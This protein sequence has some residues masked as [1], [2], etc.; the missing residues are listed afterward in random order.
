MSHVD[1]GALHAY[2]DGELGTEE[3][4][5]V[6]AHVAECPAC[7]QRLEEERALIA[8]ASE[9]LALAEPPA[10][11]VPPFR[12]GDPRPPARLW[13][14]VRLPL[15]W[16]ATV[17]LA[18]GIGMYLTSGR[19]A[20][21]LAPAADSTAVA[22]RA[23]QAQQRPSARKLAARPAAK[24]P[25]APQG[26]MEMEK[27]EALSRAQPPAPVPTPANA[28]PVAP[29]SLDSARLVLG[30]TPVALPGA[31]IIAVRR[32]R[33]IGYAAVVIVEQRLDSNTVVTLIE[34]RPS[35]LH[36]D[37]VVVTAAPEARRDADSFAAKREGE[38]PLPARAAASAP[39][40]KLEAPPGFVAGRLGAERTIGG[41]TI[42]IQGP[43]SRDSL[44]ALLLLVRPVQR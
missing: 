30:Q 38:R 18:L 43:L 33:A 37:A 36:M 32:D 15:A 10:R 21:E 29:F 24:A 20:M 3:A 41:L 22:L 31:P 25:A 39:T 5:S 17:V 8:R 13:W 34:R 4:Q 40:P 28:L 42:E 2:L 1:E 19:E 27:D 11:D 6:S 23:R 12:P 9:L 14:R 35:P 16:A 7:R 44:Q 26:Q